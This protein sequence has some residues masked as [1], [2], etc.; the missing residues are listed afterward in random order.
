MELARSPVELRN[1]GSPVL[2]RGDRSIVDQRTPQAVHHVEHVCATGIAHV[3][4]VAGEREIHRHQPSAGLQL[5]RAGEKYVLPVGAGAGAQRLELLAAGAGH[6]DVVAHRTRQCAQPV[7]GG[8][9]EPE[10]DGLGRKDRLEEARRGR[11]DED[12]VVLVAIA[13]H[14]GAAAV[15]GGEQSGVVVARKVGVGNAYGASRGTLA[16]RRDRRAVEIHRGSTVGGSVVGD[17]EQRAGACDFHLRNR[18]ARE[19]LGVVDG[20]LRTLRVGGVVAFVPH[21]DGGSC[22]VEPAHAQVP[23]A[24]SRQ[25]IGSRAQASVRDEPA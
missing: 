22:A 8:R 4:T 5:R 1:R 19:V 2:G 15:G 21:G 10:V 20:V 16:K 24:T 13:R 11:V 3:A 7:H 23:F 17:V 12:V 25:I 14:S 9:G 18:S 6:V